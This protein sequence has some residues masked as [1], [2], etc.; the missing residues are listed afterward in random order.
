MST[1]TIAKILAAPDPAFAI[2]CLTSAESVA[3][4]EE[5]AALSAVVPGLFGAAD[6]AA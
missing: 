1:P 6:G 2:R 4:Y 5:L 3:L